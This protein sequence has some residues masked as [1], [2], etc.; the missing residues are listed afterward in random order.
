MRD[1]GRGQSRLRHTPVYGTVCPRP[2]LR[3]Q[4]GRQS[5]PHGEVKGGAVFAQKQEW[6]VDPFTETVSPTERDRKWKENQKGVRCKK[7]LTAGK[8]TDA[9][10]EFSKMN[11]IK[12]LR[13]VFLKKKCHLLLGNINSLRSS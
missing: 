2:E 3:Q 4:L 9:G 6:C 11:P 8:Q 7:K 5:A 13:S 12:I 10:Q 1:Q